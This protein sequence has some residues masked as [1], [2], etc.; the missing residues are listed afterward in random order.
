MT[1][2]SE[3]KTQHTADCRGV[4]DHTADN[5][6]GL[7]NLERLIAPVPCWCLDKWEELRD[8]ISNATRPNTDKA[9]CLSQY[10]VTCVFEALLSLFCWRNVTE[11]VKSTNRDAHCRIFHL[12]IMSHVP[13]VIWCSTHSNVFMLWFRWDHYLSP[14][15]FFQSREKARKWN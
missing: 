2:V 9:T 1:K 3:A 6:W 15:L 11:C 12:K 5:Y 7:S 10:A 8:K 4:T 13:N 14:S